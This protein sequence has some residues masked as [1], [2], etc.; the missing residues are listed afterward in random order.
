[1]KTATGGLL[2]ALLLSSLVDGARAAT[3]FNA[4][5]L[6]LHSAAATLAAGDAARS[7]NSTLRSLLAAPA[8][9]AAPPAY[10]FAVR[11]RP[12]PAAWSLILGALFV[13]GCIARRRLGGR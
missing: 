13:G 7:A 11:P 1:M 8:A 12:Q 9:S 3:P 4:V 6:D 2:A 5:H 10:R